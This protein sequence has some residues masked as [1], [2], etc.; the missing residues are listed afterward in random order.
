MPVLLSARDVRYSTEGDHGRVV[1]LDGL[2]FDV[3]R[4][5]VVDVSGP[6]GAGKTTLLRA[7]AQLLPDATGTLS[8]ASETADS[9][10]P[11]EWRSKVALLPQKAVMRPGTVRDNLLMPWAFKVRQGATAPTDEKLRAALDGVGLG[12]VVLDRDAARLSVGQAAR[13]SLLRVVLTDP[14]ILL[15]DEPDAS[16]DEVSAEQ[17]ATIIREF[18]DDGRG[19]VRVRHQRADSIASRRLRLSGAQLQEV[20]GR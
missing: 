2:D 9:M 1:L 13:V 5:E 10:T 18:A 3:A 19:V 6:S 8:L 20:D 17:V 11:Q 12:E 14:D 15:L 4:G 7:L 16:L